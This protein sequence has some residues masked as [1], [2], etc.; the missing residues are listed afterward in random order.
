[1]LLLAMKLLEVLVLE[2]KIL[3]WQRLGRQKTW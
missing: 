3:D 1:L 2:K